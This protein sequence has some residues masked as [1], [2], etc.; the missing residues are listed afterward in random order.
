MEVQDIEILEELPVKSTKDEIDEAVLW[1]ANSGLQLANCPVT[2]RFVEGLYSREIFMPA[3]SLIVSEIHKTDHFYNVSWGKVHV[4]TEEDGEIEIE[5]PYGGITKVGTQRVL[6][7]ETDVL[8]TTY[9]A[10]PDNENLEQIRERIIEKYENPLLS[11]GQKKF[12]EEK[13]KF[14]DTITGSKTELIN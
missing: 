6:F 11:E 4:F 2:H 8:W 9:H 5:A 7:C 13:N 14:M 1:M 10:N 3:G 12:F